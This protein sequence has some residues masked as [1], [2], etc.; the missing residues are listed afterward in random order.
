MKYARSTDDKENKVGWQTLPDHL[1]G[2]T[3][4]AESFAS[5]F[6]AEPWGRAAGLLH[7]IG[8]ASAEFQKRLE[9]GSVVDHGTA[10]A[11]EAVARYG[12]QY[13]RFLG[14]VICGHH[15]GLPA[16][17]DAAKEGSLLRRL[18]QKVPDYSDWEHYLPQSL[19]EKADLNIPFKGVRGKL[20]FQI[21]FYIRMLY[22]SLV[23]A[24]ALDAEQATNQ[25]AS[26]LREGWV[27]LDSVQDQMNQ[28]LQNQKA[29]SADTPINR[30]RTEIREHVTRLAKS[31]KGLF[32]LTIPTGGGKTQVSL[33]FAMKH[34]REHNLKRIIYVTSFT[35][36]IEQTAQVF[37]TIL[38][39]EVVLEHHS[40]VASEESNSK[41]KKENLDD[42]AT[43]K[44]KCRLA[45]E[46]WDAPLVVTTSVQALESLFSN[47]PSRCRKLHRMADSI[48]IFDEAQMIPRIFLQPTLM[49]LGEL[50]Q[51]YGSTVVLCTATQ[52]AWDK[53][54]RHGRDEGSEILAG[55]VI[56]ELALKPKELYEEFRRVRVEY[57]AEKSDEELVE[58]FLQTEQVLCIVNT[59]RHAQNLFSLLEKNFPDKE[60]L[61]H[62]STRMC[63]HHRRAKLKEIRGRLE[64]G[65][66]C[67]VI[68]TQL[69]EAG[70]DVDFPQVYRS[71]AG[72]DSIVQAAGRCNREQ[73]RP[74]GQVFVFKPADSKDLPP[75]DFTRYAEIAEEIF[76][77]YSDPMCLE[78]V[79]GYF[80]KL[81]A[82]DGKVSLDKKG[83]LAELEKEWRI[84]DLLFDFPQIAKDF[85]LIDSAT[86]SLIIP[87]GPFFS[88][89][90]DKKE[91]EEK[92][93][94]E[95]L[96]E[97]EKMIY[98]EVS[99]VRLARKMQPITIQV[100]AHELRK[101]EEMKL[102]HCYQDRD[103]KSGYWVLTDEASYDPEQGLTL[104]DA[105]EAK[106]YIF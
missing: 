103:K 55:Q 61:F 78:A 97:I 56:Q 64:Q 69:I 51:N 8:K 7:D 80:R 29:R 85:Q 60:G 26:A 53:V 14:Y 27:T 34:T 71:I 2:V 9:G 25:D 22:S 92:S 37:R 31:E 99:P 45:T 33:D 59:R 6:H 32:S 48:L 76:A 65:L 70:V 62:L 90:K 74:E 10:G 84:E 83:I 36:I 89:E 86:E 13:G 43:F 105:L 42:G 102:V 15:G 50:V 79:E 24:D 38:G 82:M 41:A 68:S 1:A 101:L 54:R 91:L 93:F 20:G 17:G 44:E 66:S 46:N 28:F 63:P 75:G 18:E 87:W 88:V 47:K 35:S 49:A 98:N 57:V 5:S 104:R 95:C 72:I 52:P 40:N 3:E 21:A 96:E 19:P 4:L 77:E 30:R 39:D 73:K 23:D 11:K 58:K 100:Y 81:Y 67:R 12:D 94:S 16:G 106:V